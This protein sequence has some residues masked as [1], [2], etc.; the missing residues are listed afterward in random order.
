MRVEPWFP[1]PCRDLGYSQR[2]GLAAR[3]LSTN[4]RLVMSAPDLAA[5]TL[6][7]VKNGAING[8]SLEASSL[9]RDHGALVFV[10]RRPG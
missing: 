3:Q 9:W 1:S 2:A 8:D 4:R 7:P 10:V 6:R 5:T